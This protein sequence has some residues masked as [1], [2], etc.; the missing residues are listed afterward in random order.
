MF[1]LVFGLGFLVH[2]YVFPNT[3]INQNVNF[4]DLLTKQKL[5]GNK[6]ANQTFL[7]E[8]KVSY[9]NGSFK[10]TRVVMHTGDYIEIINQNK[11]TY[12]ELISNNT[13]L[14]TPRP[15]GYTEQVR[16]ILPEAGTYTVFDKSNKNVS[17][18]IVVLSPQ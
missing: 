6:K 7:L 16:S 13:A 14:S 18:V 3:L 15:Y 2:A 5:A 1:L 17:L 11:D 9:I 12:M 10:P 8:N 4:E